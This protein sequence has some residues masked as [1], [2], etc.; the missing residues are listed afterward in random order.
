MQAL[1]RR[2]H[3][4]I[5]IPT[6]GPADLGRVFLLAELAV[7]VAGWGLEINPF[8]QP[9]VQQA[10]DATKRVLADY[11]AEHELPAIADAD[12]GGAARAACSTRRR[13]TTS[14]SWPTASPRPSS[15]RPPRELREAIRDATQATTTFG[16]GPRFLHS[17]G[18]FHK[19]GPKTGR[20]LQLLHDGPE[21]RRDPGRAVHVHDAQERAGDRRPEDAARA[22]A[23]GRARAPARRGPCGRA[24]RPDRDDQGAGQHVTQIGF[25]GLGKMG[26]NMVH[27][28]RRDSEHE[29]VAFD[30]DEKAVKQAVKN[31][32]VGRGLAEGARQAAA[33]AAD[34]LDHGARRR[35]DPGDGGQARQAARPRRHD[36]RR[37]QLEVDRR[38]APRG[39]TENAAASTTST[40]A[41]PAACGG[42]KSATA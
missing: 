14:R 18:Q 38:Q 25:V 15:T 31:G 39:G 9:N 2:G 21:R 34:R 17:T 10:K 30:F 41:P 4:L 42:W 5:T 27:R 36:R 35:A 33:G 26:G 23:A 6:R 19:G 16:Y 20:F 8:D 1:A 24:A 7:A 12:D 29:V 11:E 28:I 3:P 13:R 32:A 22:R 40:S 37:R